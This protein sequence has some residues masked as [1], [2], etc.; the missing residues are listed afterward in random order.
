[1]ARKAVVTEMNH[2]A[3]KILI[4]ATLAFKA[5]ELDAF[6]DIE[7]ITIWNKYIDQAEMLMY[8]FVQMGIIKIP[9]KLFKC[10]L[11]DRAYPTAEEATACARADHNRKDKEAL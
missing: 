3:P 2:P 6:N 7:Q 10:L 9:K 4:A 8:H 1:M 11:C 5:D